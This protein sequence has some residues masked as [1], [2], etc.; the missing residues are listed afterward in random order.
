MLHPRRGWPG[1]VIF[2][3]TQNDCTRLYR[4]LDHHNPDFKGHIVA[5]HGGFPERE[6]E[7]ALEN[8]KSRKNHVLIS[9]QALANGISIDHAHIVVHF[10]LPFDRRNSTL[11]QKLMCQYLHKSRVLSSSANY[12]RSYTYY[13]K[14]DA[15]LFP[16]LAEHLA[17]CGQR[18]TGKIM[19]RFR[20]GENILNSRL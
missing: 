10:H 15:D 18:D 12:P 11:P 16:F 8:F 13:D 1:I 20:N 6:R 17:N 9:T 4:Y 19:E 14:L 2:A 3:N 7:E 5:R